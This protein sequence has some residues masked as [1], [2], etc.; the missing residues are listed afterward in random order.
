[1]SKYIK[2]LT[3]DISGAPPRVRITAKQGDNKSRYLKIT[4]VDGE[5]KVVLDDNENADFRC[6]KPDDTSCILPSTKE[7][8]G[9]ILVEL[10]KQVLAVAGEVR[11]DVAVSDENGMVLS[12]SYF[13]IDVEPAATNGNYTPSRPFQKFARE[14]DMNG[15][16]IRNLPIP[17]EN[18]DAV[19]KGYV[20]EKLG[21]I[22]VPV[23]D[24]LDENSVN[25]IQNAVVA[26]EVQGI[27][28]IVN[29][30]RVTYEELTKPSPS[31]THYS[32]S[33]NI[34]WTTYIA[35]FMFTFDSETKQAQITEERTNLPPLTY[36]FTEGGY[37]T[38]VKYLCEFSNE[39]LILDA[40]KIEP[41]ITEYTP[42]PIYLTELTS[43][44]EELGG[45]FSFR[46]DFNS[47]MSGSQLTMGYNFLFEFPDEETRNLFY[48][49]YVSLLL[50]AWCG[51]FSETY[52]F[53]TT[54]EEMI[55]KRR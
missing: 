44:A 10:D 36:D 37:V 30:V 55:S 15:Y 45:I 6:I 40:S 39:A 53:E 52:T 54:P 31:K 1:M 16:G 35:Y 33:Y 34:S 25:A 38:S 17:S 43:I 18:G 8:D 11:A 46:R 9:T 4:L 29:G 51:M 12:S 24:T 7:A 23:D 47:S 41:E 20:D 48:S 3:L 19:N 14:I 22:E 5:T 27:K 28:N 49:E 13:F 21:K 32:D 50:G 26:K 2:S 42:I